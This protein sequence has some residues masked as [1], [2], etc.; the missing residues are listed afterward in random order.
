VRTTR[1]HIEAHRGER[2]HEP[3]RVE[4]RATARGKILRR[5]VIPRDGWA[6]IFFKEVIQ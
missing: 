6:G 4:P 5:R 1:G 2:R 3:A